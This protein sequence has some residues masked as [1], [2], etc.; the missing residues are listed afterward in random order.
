MKIKER[1]KIRNGFIQRTGSSA[2][3]VQADLGNSAPYA[4]SNRASP[5]HLGRRHGGRSHT[6]PLRAV[7]AA[8]F[9]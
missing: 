7:R 1:S 8:V 5:R 3:R 9:P 2:V 4:K 6:H